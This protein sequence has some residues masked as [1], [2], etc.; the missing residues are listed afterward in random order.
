MFAV[1][2]KFENAN[3]F[4]N[5][6]GHKP[7]PK[8]IEECQKS[9]A[10]GYRRVFPLQKQ[11]HGVNVLYVMALQSDHALRIVAYSTA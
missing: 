1:S 3:H 10:E 5:H 7:S 9:I 4:S 6:P 11:D 2:A 8:K